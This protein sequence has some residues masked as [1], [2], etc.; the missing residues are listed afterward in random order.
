M[1]LVRDL[2]ASP[3]PP[4]LCSPDVF[5]FFSFVLISLFQVQE[6]AS[7]FYCLLVAYGIAK[8]EEAEVFQPGEGGAGGKEEERAVSDKAALLKAGMKGAA[9]GQGEGEWKRRGWEEGGGGVVCVFQ[10]FF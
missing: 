7:S 4:R 5:F 10:H 2:C 6:R 1:T 3:L 9:N 8:E